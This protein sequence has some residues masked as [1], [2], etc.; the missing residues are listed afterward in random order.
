ML[1]VVLPL[2]LTCG[3]SRF[4]SQSDNRQSLRVRFDRTA[5]M[6]VLLCKAKEKKYTCRPPYIT[7]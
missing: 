4:I 1:P 2:N 6:N 7:S 5:A 3:R